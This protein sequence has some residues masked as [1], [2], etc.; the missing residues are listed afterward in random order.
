MGAE[1]VWW[2]RRGFTR[3][4]E[5]PNVH[6]S[7][8]RPSKHHQNSTRRHP[9]RHRNSETVAEKGRKRAKF[10][11]VRRRGVQW[12]GG[13]AEGCPGKSKPVTTTTTTTTTTPNPEQVGPRPLSQARFRVFRDNTT[14]TQNNN[15]K[16]QHNTTTQ[17]N[18]TTTHN[19]TTQQNNTTTTHNNTTTT[20][21]NNTTQQ[22]KTTTQNNNTQHNNR[23][24]L[25]KVG[26]QIGQSRF[27][28]SR[29]GQ[30]R[31]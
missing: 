12:R 8:F 2:G 27:G 21:H 19:T 16:Q 9:E 4:P 5:S 22:H 28:Q 10:W 18:N 30:S 14:T 23:P 15:T 6:I 7:G 20:Q 1:Q 13:P 17:H 3:Q 11:A 24:R 31:P 26:R 25:A 29:F